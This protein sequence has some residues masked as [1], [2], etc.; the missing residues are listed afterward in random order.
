M[1]QNITDKPMPR[2]YAKAIEEL[3]NIVRAMQGDQVDID[4]LAAYTARS[5][6]LLK[7]CKE[8]LLTTDE[9]LKKLLAEL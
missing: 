7:M 6:K 1:E 3:E 9:E 4:N 5:L 2:S 8:R